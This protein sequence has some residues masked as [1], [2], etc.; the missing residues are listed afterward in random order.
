MKSLS[1]TDFV[2]FAISSGTPK[3]T[4]VRQIKNRP[5][6]YHP[7]RDFYKKIREAVIEFHETGKT[8]KRLFD[9]ILKGLHQNKIKHYSECI[10]GYKKFLGKKKFQWFSPPTDE[11]SPSSI[12]IR[13]NPELGLIFDGVPHVIKLYFKKDGLSKARIDIILLLLH[14]TLSGQSTSGTKF[15]VLDVQKGK[16]F[17]NESPDQSFMPLLL[18]EAQSFRVMWDQI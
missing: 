16:L 12:S 9:K 5:E 3:L 17:G 15:C 6:D 18:G 14:D 11:W 2:D 1:L 7:A 10:K 4:K 8:D 13:I